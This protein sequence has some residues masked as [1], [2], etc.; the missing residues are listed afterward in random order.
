MKS[1]F[2]EKKLLVLGAT[3]LIIDIVKHAQNMGIYVIVADYYQDSPAKKYADE[4]L[5]LDATDVDAIVDYCL[6]NKIDAVTT[7]F[8]DVLLNPCYEVC[9]RLGLPFFAT[10]KMIEMS[11]NKTVFKQTCEK[12]GVPVPNTY[13]VGQK[14]EEGEKS[15]LQYPV[16]VKPLDASGSRGAGVCY[17]KTELFKQFET[18]KEF[19]DSDTVI[20]EE[21]ITGREFL[22]DYIAV[23]G[24]YR[25]LE[26]FDRYVCDDRGSAINYANLSIAPSCSLKAYYNSVNEKVIHMFKSEGIIDGLV[27]L[28]GHFDGEKITFYEMG[29]RLGGSFYNIEQAILGTNTIDMIIRLAFTGKM[30]DLSSID[31]KVACFNR[32]G[33]SYNFLLSGENKTVS[34]IQ[35]KEKIEQISSVV[36]TIQR[37][38][39]NKNYYN[40]RIVDTPALT[41]HFVENNLSELKKTVSYMNDV[42]DIVDGN[43]NTMLL[44]KFNPNTLDELRGR[45]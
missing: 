39:E 27:F 8:L 44:N 22:L 11:T 20:I 30:A 7:G 28:Q 21:Y 40:E 6:N 26:S 29:C 31:E 15:V 13:Y 38:K 32:L 45:F 41:I 4:A 35:G 1:K 16:F 3:D 23:D 24:E 18:A 33:A 34:R 10:K 5:L 36:E 14:W 19:S 43:G 2:A 12:Y 17:N 9:Q 42:F 25:L 37:V